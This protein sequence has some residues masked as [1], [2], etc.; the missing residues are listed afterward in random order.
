LREDF[1]KKSS[2]SD[3]E[4][5]MRE[6]QLKHVGLVL[7][8]IPIKKKKKSSPVSQVI[9]DGNKSVKALI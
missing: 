1:S 5:I 9:T 7:K 3:L 8:T 2:I 6:K 4:N